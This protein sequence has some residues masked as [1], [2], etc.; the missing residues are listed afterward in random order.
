[1][2]Q[3]GAKPEGKQ[4]RDTIWDTSTANGSLTG[5]VTQSTPTFQIF[6]LPLQISTNWE[7]N[8]I[9]YKKKKKYVFIEQEISQF[10]KALI[11]GL[12]IKD[13]GTII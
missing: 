10:T 1:M 6:I 7:K 4:K 3:H 9:E 8:A 12:F 11:L 5:Y 13:T 2:N